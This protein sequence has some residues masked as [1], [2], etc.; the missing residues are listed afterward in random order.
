MNKKTY[1]ILIVLLF[2]AGICKAQEKEQ[3]NFEDWEN[4]PEKVVPGDR[5]TAPSDATVL[6]SDNLGLWEFYDGSEVS[7][8]ASKKGFKVVPKTQSIQTKEAFGSCQLHIE[9][10]VPKN[11]D[12]GKTDNWGNSGI[13]FMGRYELQVYDSYNDVHKMNYNGQQAGSIY[14]Q[15]SPLVN[16]CVPTGEWESYDVVFSAP[17]F[18]TDGSVKTPAYFT[19]FQNGI[20]IQNHAEVTGTTWN[21]KYEKHKSKWPMLIQSHGSAVEYRNIWI[22]EL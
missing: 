5:K 18:N 17:E 11:E 14:N 9:W 8:P 10:R 1:S 16:C 12:H 21:G 13:K 3:N 20:L 4:K 19:V 6:F 15:H 2:V 22:R 7:W